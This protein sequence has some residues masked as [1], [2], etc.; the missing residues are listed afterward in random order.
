MARDQFRELAEQ[1]KALLA[2]EQAERI[3]K[4]QQ[5]AANLARQQKEFAD[6]PATEAQNPGI[7]NRPRDPDSP[8]PMPGAGRANRDAQPNQEMRGLGGKARDLAE[9]A[10]TL[11]DVLGAASKPEAP[12]DQKSGEGISRIMQ[13][14]DLKGVADRLAQLPDQIAN[15]K[16]QDAR[17]TAGDGAERMESAAE[18]LG[19]LHRS[20][21]APKVAELARLEKDAAQLNDQLDKLDNDSK[22]TDWHVEADDLLNKL[23][24]AG[25]DQQ[26]QT[27]FR[28]E[29][30]KAGWGGDIVR[31]RWAWGRTTGGTFAAPARY[32]MLL[33]R[34]TE[35]LRSRMQEYLL[36]DTQATGD[37]AIPPQYQELVDRYYRVL[38]AEGKDTGSSPAPD[39]KESGGNN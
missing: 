32:R 5:M 2:Q 25:I 34:L 12:Q 15:R 6:R 38:A 1:V 21:V 26:W 31:S 13:A 29:M 37:E 35:S 28:D 4:A 23:D 33:A 22:V 30:R 11:A 10:K 14:L 7:G 36:G 9:K 39:S 27:E 16:L 3:A 20:I 17:A 24:D 19:V 18:Q 8:M